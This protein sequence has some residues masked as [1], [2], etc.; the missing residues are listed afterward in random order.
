V[1]GWRA[2]AIGRDG[3]S[4]ARAAALRRLHVRPN[5]LAPLANR[6]LH[7]PDR[8]GRHQGI[9]CSRSTAEYAEGRRRG[10]REDLLGSMLDGPTVGSQRTLGL[11]GFLPAETLWVRPPPSAL[12]SSAA[13]LPL[14]SCEEPSRL[15]RLRT[16]GFMFAPVGTAARTGSAATTSHRRS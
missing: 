12:R 11:L 10:E 16:A 1:T 15:E 14:R 13:I 8:S 9:A 3:R 5:E 6:D 2:D 4:P 7:V